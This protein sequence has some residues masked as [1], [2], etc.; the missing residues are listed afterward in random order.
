MM[1]CTNSII[2]NNLFNLPYAMN[3]YETLS[4]GGDLLK[5]RPIHLD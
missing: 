2:C 5:N 3:S 1:S 4:R